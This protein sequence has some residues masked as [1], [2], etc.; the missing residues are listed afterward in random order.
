LVIVGCALLLAV[1]VTAHSL[2]LMGIGVGL[3]M[4][5]GHNEANETA[6]TGITT[7]VARQVST[8]TW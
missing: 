8:R 5:A 1:L 7:S 6:P 4:A 3:A 2:P